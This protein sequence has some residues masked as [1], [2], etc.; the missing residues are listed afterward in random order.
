[1]LPPKDAVALP[2]RPAYLVAP[3]G[4]VWSHKTERFLS[5]SGY[6]GSSAGRRVRIGHLTYRVR[7]LV[8]VLHGSIMAYEERIDAEY[9]DVA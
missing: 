7:D 9:E 2:H 5:E 1:M 4:R 8:A 6:P 3:D